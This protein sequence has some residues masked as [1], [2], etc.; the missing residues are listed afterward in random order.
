MEAFF[1]EAESSRFQSCI[2]LFAL[3]AR[4]AKLRSRKTFL[5]NI[6]EAN[7]TAPPPPAPP[8]FAV[9]GI[10]RCRLADLTVEAADRF[11]LVG[12]RNLKPNYTALKKREAADFVATKTKQ[13]TTI[14]N[15]SGFSATEVRLPLQKYAF[16]ASNVGIAAAAGSLELW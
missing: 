11:S 10:C 7:T 3:W 13:T 2:E 8:I 5:I 4:K 1:A 15:T 14:K 6:S 9:T 12:L 16:V